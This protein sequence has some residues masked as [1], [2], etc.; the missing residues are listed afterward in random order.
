MNT[1]FRGMF[2]FVFLKF[3]SLEISSHLWLSHYWARSMLKMLDSP[4]TCFLRI[5][6]HG[7]RVFQ[8]SAWLTAYW[9]ELCNKID[10]VCT[11][12]TLMIVSWGARPTTKTSGDIGNLK[13]LAKAT[14][15]HFPKDWDI[16]PTFSLIFFT[17]E[18]NTATF[19]TSFNFHLTWLRQKA[20]YLKSKKNENADESSVLSH[21]L[22]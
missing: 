4:F 5:G 9:G 10:I 18:L 15:T 8:T 16:S 1:A 3:V 17:K 2:F 7:L 6:M 12:E 20:T 14:M 19:G 11:S 22:T 21:N 13:H